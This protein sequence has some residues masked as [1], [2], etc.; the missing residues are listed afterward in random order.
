M[1]ATVKQQGRLAGLDAL[2]GLAALGVLFWHY[3]AHFNATPLADW[4][5]PFYN[6][7]LY[8]VDVFFVLSGFLLGT[9]YS[10]PSSWRAFLFKRMARLFPLHWVT[11]VVVAVLQ[12]WYMQLTGAGFIY[13]YNDS[14]HFFLNLGLLQYVGLQEGF[15][16]NGPAWS[17]SVEWLVNLIFVML[18]LLPRLRGALTATLVIGS[19]TSLWF[20]GGRVIESSSLWGWLDPA[21]VRGV[22]GFFT[23]VGLASIMQSKPALSHLWDGIGLTAGATLIVFMNNRELQQMSGVDFAIVGLAIPGM[24][25]GF[26]NGATLVR[27]SQWRGLVWLGEVSFSVYLWHFPAQIVMGMIVAC[28]TEIQFTSTWVLVGF[29]TTCYVVG[30][31]SFVFLERPAQRFATESKAGQWFFRKG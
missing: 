9:L 15:S 31:L 7:G 26:I 18:L 25:A 6:A 13:T 20:L 10:E 8:L 21:L 29:I 4:L 14:L 16:F 22:F 11:L 5:S 27:V 19:A 17:I 24:V 1:G 23:G 3:G 30:H 2:R 12:H 28:G